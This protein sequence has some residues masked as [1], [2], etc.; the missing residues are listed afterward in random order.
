MWLPCFPNG[1]RDLSPL[2][3]LLEEFGVQVP[4]TR[5]C[6]RVWILSPQGTRAQVLVG[7]GVRVPGCSSTKGR[8]WTQPMLC[9]IYIYIYILM[10]RAEFLRR[11]DSCMG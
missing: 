2:D 4:E 1:L 10:L 8:R 3:A 7:S 6:C 5:V 11:M 9:D